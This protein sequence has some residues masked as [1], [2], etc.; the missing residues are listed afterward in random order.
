[1]SIRDLS[2]SLLILTFAAVV[3]GPSEVWAQ[4]VELKQQWQ[5]GRRYVQTVQMQQMTKLAAADQNVEQKMDVTLEMS[6]TVALHEDK[7]RKRLTV[8][9][10]RIAMRM[11]MGGEDVIFDSAAP[12]ADP[13]GIGK[14]F[15]SLTGKQ[16]RMLVNERD[17][18]T[19]LENFEEFMGA[20]GPGGAANPMAGIL[21]QESLTEM[22]KQS[23]LRALP[24]APVSPGDSWPWTYEMIMPQIGSVGTAGTYTY[25]GQAER[26]GHQCAEIELDGK[27]RLN[28]DPAEALAGAEG[29]GAVPMGMKLTGGKMTGTVWFDAALGM[30]R[31]IDTALETELTIEN[32][33]APEQKI[34][35]PSRQVL[36][37][38]LL[39]VDEVQ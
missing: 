21:T 22:M 37:V 9:Y 8:K 30:A 20:L 38:R 16:L 10:G 25:R 29:A 11:N 18:V 14:Q 33:A 15:A 35:I 6:T 2:P 24:T 28:I 23:Y 26:E 4:A 36:I 27:L 5:V 31:E 12:D 39:Q 34:T 7:V 32:P 13:S 19:E 1:M 17:E 3:G